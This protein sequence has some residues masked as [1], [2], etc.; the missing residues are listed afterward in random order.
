MN[1]KLRIFLITAGCLLVLLPA[2][3][4]TEENWR[5][6]RAWENYK[7]Q[8]EAQGEHLDMAPFIPPPVPDEKNFML[9]P[10]FAPLFD[11]NDDPKVML[12]GSDIELDHVSPDIVH[13]YAKESPPISKGGWN[14][15]LP[16]DDFKGWQTY[17]RAELHDVKLDKSPAEDVLTALSRYDPLLAVLRDAAA[18]RPLSRAPL[19]YGKGFMMRLS[20]YSVMQKLIKILDMRARAELELNRTDD[21]SAD[22]QL[23]FH[24]LES[25]KS[26]PLLISGL[27]RITWFSILMQP[28]WEGIASHRWTDAQLA[29]LEDHLRI[30]F[31]A[32]F[33]STIRSERAVSISSLLETD[34]RLLAQFYSLN[35]NAMNTIIGLSRVFSALVYQ[36]Q[37]SMCQLI[38]E[39]ILPLADV[40]TQR[41]NAHEAARTREFFDNPRNF[42]P[43]SFLAKNT[44]PVYVSI[45]KKYALAQTCANEALIACEIERYRIAHGTLPAT[46]EDLHMTD[47]PHDIIN[48]QPLHYRVT[49][50]DYILYSVGWNGTDDG[51]KVEFQKNTSQIVDIDQG[52]WVWSLK[53]LVAPDPTPATADTGARRVRRMPPAP[54]P[55]PTPP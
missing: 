28:L 51:G 32:D 35:K 18:T 55:A 6:K 27:V 33:E 2:L 1:R 40:K 30:D 50:D 26:D 48:G 19:Q 12:S 34:P 3:L 23:G 29:Q 5:G 17:Y 4:V 38:Q 41:F 22:L 24:L 20:H 47:L 7:T 16:R 21:A 25:I 15:G 37:L 14:K 31:L 43:Y 13:D 10:V 53:P 54:V 39:R 8:M 45:A 9:N 42:S 36:N 49:G 46:L 11:D 44:L 52:D